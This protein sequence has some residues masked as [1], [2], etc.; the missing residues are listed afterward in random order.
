MY[1]G[2]PA[3]WEETLPARLREEA[4]KPLPE[5]ASRRVVLLR[6]VET[7]SDFD[8]VCALAPVDVLVPRSARPLGVDSYA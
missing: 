6:C 3:R 7:P 4:E 8:A 5:G 1:C 2:F